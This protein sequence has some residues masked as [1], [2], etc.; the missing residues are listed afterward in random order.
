M[1]EAGGAGVCRCPAAHPP[2]LSTPGGRASSQPGPGDD[3][4]APLP[5]GRGRAEVGV[6]A[7][8]RSSWKMNNPSDRG[9]RAARG[10]KLVQ[11]WAGKGKKRRPAHAWTTRGRYGED[12]PL[13]LGEGRPEPGSSA[14]SIKGSQR[15]EGNVTM[16]FE[17]WAKNQILRY[18]S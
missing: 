3:P 4:R 6:Q 5:P 16:T 7:P 14:H 12:A 11:I 8:A 18:E 13:S 15:V 2:W 9:S 1:E 10:G 17:N